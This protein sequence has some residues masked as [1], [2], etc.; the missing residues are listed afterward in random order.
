MTQGPSVYASL[1]RL[2]NVT[3]RYVD[4][5]VAAGRDGRI[6]LISEGRRISYGEVLE[7]VNRCG[8]A[9]SRLGLRMEQRVLV[10]LPDCPEFVYLFWGAIKIGA[11]PIPTNVLLKPEDYEYVL[12]DSRADAAIVCAPLVPAIERIRP[13]LR[14]LH[15]LVTVGHRDPA[16]PELSDLMHAESAELDPVKTTKDDVAFW[17]Y[18]SGTTGI[19]KAAVHLHHDPVITCE[20][21][22]RHLLEIAEDDICYSIAKLFFAYGLGNA[23]LAS[24]YVGAAAVLDPA[25]FEPGRTFETIARERPTLFFAVP[26][27]YAALLQVPDAEHRYDLSSVRR[28]VSAGESL[29]KAIY[30]RWLK[31]FGLEILDGIGSTELLNIFIANRAGHVRAGSS[32]TILPGYQAR[33]LD[34]AGAAVPDGEIGNLWI[35]GE[36]ACSCY[37][38]QHERTRLTMVGDWVRTGDKYSRDADG[39][40][41]YAGRSDDMIKVGGL[42]VSPAEV[43]AALVE[44]EAVLEAGVVGVEDEEGLVKPVAYV[45]W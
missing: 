37:W 26:T 18:S 31:R 20:A 30:E 19:P 32:G 17:L 22:G 8:N 43:E 5:H 12:N 40:F 36:S 3:T 15:H 41:W 39:Y 1:P 28:C 33:I 27:A 16:Y 7:N 2:F 23:L 29:P 42:W 45:V 25:R 13:R 21:S 44:H 24:F 38:N 14:Y 10:L 35:N 4:H 9:L 34:D 11:V 6:A